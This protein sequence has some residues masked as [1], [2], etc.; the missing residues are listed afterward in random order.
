[1]TSTRI[2]LA[3]PGSLVGGLAVFTWVR[4]EE[5]THW[6]G[7]P[8]PALVVPI[9]LTYL[10]AAAAGLLLVKDGV[11]RWWWVP[12]TALVIFGFPVDHWVGWSVI[13]TRFGVTAGSIVDLLAV[14]APAGV[15]WL[16]ARGRRVGI[17]G[18][19]IPALLI[20]TISAI[21][22]MRVG[23][24]GPDLS[25]PVG[26]ALLALGILS[27]SSSWQRASA[28]LLIAV[29]LG[30]QIPAAF[31][32]SLS[33]GSVGPIAIADA[34]V[35]IAVAVLAFSIAPLTPMV[36]RLLARNAGSAPARA[37]S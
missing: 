8:M 30:A 1:M 14:L 12:G 17:H 7:H 31:A 13:T 6:G 29:S 26:A 9:V 3:T 22:T 16:G 23:I 11:T 5:V 21:I 25:L 32:V 28:F 36:R 4:W 2:R 18:R 37:P 27:R 19:L 20:G 35:D 24:D 34:S 33:Q 10:A 15:A